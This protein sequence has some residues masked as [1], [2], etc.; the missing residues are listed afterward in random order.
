VKIKSLKSIVTAGIMLTVIMSTAAFA[1]AGAP[2]SLMSKCMVLTVV[3]EL[4]L[5]KDQVQTM[6]NIANQFEKD[7]EAGRQAF[8]AV[9]EP[10]YQKLVAGETVDPEDIHDALADMPR[11]NKGNRTEMRKQVEAFWATLTPDQQETL[12]DLEP[13]MRMNKGGEGMHG[14]MGPGPEGMEPPEGAPF[15]GRLDQG[16]G[17]NPNRGMLYMT[18]DTATASDQPPPPPHGKGK[19]GKHAKKDAGIMKLTHLLMM[20]AASEAL[21]DRLAHM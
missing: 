5:N 1:Q 21:S 20:P 6:A 18:A 3:N 14:M 12:R 2:E 10:F 8:N 17:N 11:A 4:E 16:P 15:E 9:L 13:P 19:K 7:H